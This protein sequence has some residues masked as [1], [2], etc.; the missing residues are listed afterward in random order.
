MN[1]PID[2]F[3]QMLNMGQNPQTIINQLLGQN[4]QLKTL[5]NQAKQSGMT[6]QQFCMQYA[7]QNNINM[8]PFIN[9]LNQHNIRL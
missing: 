1:N 7:R 3:M 8:E 5:L 4:P 2:A 9:V 6:P